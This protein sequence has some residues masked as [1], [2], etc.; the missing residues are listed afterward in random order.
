MQN[1]IE[2]KYFCE[3]HEITLDQFTGKERIEGSLDLE[4]VTSLP[5]GFNPTVGG[6]L[7]L[8]SGLTAETKKFDSSIQGF[9]KPSKEMSEVIKKLGHKSGQAMIQQLGLH[10]SLI[11]LR[12]AVKGDAAAFAGLFGSVEA[13][14]A[15]LALTGD[16]S[17]A[18][19]K[20]TEAMYNSTGI[21]NQ[22]FLAQINNLGDLWKMIKNIGSNAFTKIG[23]KI[24][25]VLKQM[26]EKALPCINALFGEFE[27]YLDVA[28]ERIGNFL[29]TIDWTPVIARLLKAKDAVVGFIQG[30]DFKKLISDLKSIG[31]KIL[32][33]F[34]WL[35]KNK[36]SILSWAIAIG[37]AFL[38][39]KVTTGILKG[40]IHSIE[41][42]GTKARVV[43]DD[44]SQIVTLPLT[45]PFYWRAEMGNVQIGEEVY[46]DED[47]SL[48]GMIHG[49]TNGEWDNTFR[50]T[51]TVTE[52]V[53]AGGI[54]LKNYTYGGVE[55]G[56]SSTGQPE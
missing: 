18:M 47:P 45:I 48:G 29:G 6:W 13:V 39:F 3:R 54:S 14:N 52:D 24:T 4:S 2:I 17:D 41:S 49:R 9:L 43:P 51:L 21:A 34:G 28:S 46:Y 10:K 15:V 8:R 55:A 23:M 44:N 7:N 30:I 26:A 11:V 32:E 42:G 37:K 53:T 31:S 50:G 25:P 35:W 16:Q 40:K 27:Q 1:E 38:I 12:K 19:T 33:A 56:G 36:D 5:A 22:S 20:K